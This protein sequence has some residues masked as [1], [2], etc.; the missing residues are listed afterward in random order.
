MLELLSREELEVNEIL[1]VMD[2]EAGGISWKCVSGYVDGKLKL[3]IWASYSRSEIQRG[4]NKIP[5]LQDK[6][7]TYNS[8]T[9]DN[10]MG[11]R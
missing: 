6:V 4:I 9:R 11:V 7:P 2:G 3:V 10:E 1:W 8:K 5:F